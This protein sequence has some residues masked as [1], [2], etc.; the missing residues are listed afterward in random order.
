[1][2]DTLNEKISS[3]KKDY[4]RQIDEIESKMSNAEEKQ[5]EISR[6]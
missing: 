4:E 2:E 6:A 3:M 1:M 5:K